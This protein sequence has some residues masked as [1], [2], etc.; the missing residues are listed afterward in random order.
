M[1][2]SSYTCDNVAA[3]HFFW[4]R[5]KKQHKFPRSSTPPPVTFTFAAMTRVILLTLLACL[6]GVFAPPATHAAVPPVGAACAEWCIH[7]PPLTW[8]TAADCQGCTPADR[9]PRS[10]LPLIMMRRVSLTRV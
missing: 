10:Y 7:M 9:T 8:A 3:S 5:T 2:T 6:L 1:I 4:A